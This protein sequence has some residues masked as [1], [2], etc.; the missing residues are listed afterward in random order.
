MRKLS[1]AYIPKGGTFNSPYGIVLATGGIDISAKHN[2]YWDSENGCV[3]VEWLKNPKLVFYLSQDKFHCWQF[4]EAEELAR[5]QA[6]A[7]RGV[8]IAE[9]LRKIEGET[10][11]QIGEVVKAPKKRGRPPGSKNK[12]K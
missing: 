9:K 7:A 12:T 10:A 3:K 11:N 5:K 1:Y 2:A 4:D 8:A 6:Q